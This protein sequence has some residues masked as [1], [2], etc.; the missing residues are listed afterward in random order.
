M[1]ASPP[2][3]LPT[4]TRF[5]VTIVGTSLPCSLLAASLALSG[6][7]VLHLDPN[8]F[9]SSSWATLSLPQLTPYLTPAAPSSTPPIPALPPSFGSNPTITPLPAPAS[10]L[11]P[12]GATLLPPHRLSLPLQS[13]LQ[14][15]FLLDLICKPLLASASLLSLLAKTNLGHYIS[16]RP[17]DA[18]YL[19]FPPPQNLQIVPCSRSAVFQSTFLS[20]IEKRLLMRIL[21]FCLNPDPAPAPTTTFDSLLASMSATP[22]LISFL[23]ECVANTPL[24]APAEHAINSIRIFQQSLFRFQTPTPYLY[25]DYGT[26]EL[27]Q[28]FCRLCAVHGG[29]YVLGRGINAVVASEDG[30][31]NAVVTTVG[32]VVETSKVFIGSELMQTRQDEGM[33]WRICAVVD[34][35]LVRDAGVRR[36]LICGGGV[37]IWMLDE[38]VKVCKDG[39]R[40]VCAEGGAGIGVDEVKRELGRYVEWEEEG[41]SGEDEEG[42][43][44]STEG[45]QAVEKARL[46]WGIAYG[47]GIGGGGEGEGGVEVVGS[48]WAEW[49]A[50]RAVEEARRCFG[51]VKPVEEFFG[52]EDKA[53][54]ENGYHSDGEDK[55]EEE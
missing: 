52:M 21:K 42:E 5:D 23:S 46:V 4:D 3:R 32:E 17:L 44:Q 1:N 18:I 30:G 48:E 54:A 50:E 16:F 15:R 55:E 36:A 33:V 35:K 29:V 43:K 31:K 27:P 7:S 40:V 22:K 51:L 24:H 28:A 19:T 34:G 10:P 25:P 47:R 41:F 45:S 38:G 2:H 9:Y 39:W 13:D 14:P 20:N 53:G 11:F 37:R 12:H 6:C 8:A 26:G 49:D